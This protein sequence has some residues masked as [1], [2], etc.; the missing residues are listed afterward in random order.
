MRDGGAVGYKVEG[1]A[2]IIRTQLENGQVPRPTNPDGMGSRRIVARLCLGVEYV[3]ILVR[4]QAG[5]CPPES[6]LGCWIDG[7]SLPL[8]VFAV[9]SSACGLAGLH[10]G[11]SAQSQ[12]AVGMKLTM[13]QKLAF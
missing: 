10:Q 8:T 1:G 7:S 6:A 13:E 2:R 4:T 9:R 5:A 12:Y 11:R 3:W